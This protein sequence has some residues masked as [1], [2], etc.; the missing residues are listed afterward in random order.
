MYSLQTALL[1]LNKKGQAWDKNTKY[2]QF[3]SC[4]LRPYWLRFH[5]SSETTLTYNMAFLGIL[6][7]LW[8]TNVSQVCQGCC[9]WCMCKVCSSLGQKWGNE[10]DITGSKIILKSP[11]QWMKTNFKNSSVWRFLLS[12]GYAILVKIWKWLKLLN[13]FPLI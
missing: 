3:Y 13:S 11:L 5:G 8:K 2:S 4:W 1:A 9:P 6:M 12:S 7:H 10:R